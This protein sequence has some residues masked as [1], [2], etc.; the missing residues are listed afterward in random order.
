VLGRNHRRREKK[1]SRQETIAHQS[2][3]FFVIHAH[4]I[5]PD[6]ARSSTQ[7]AMRDVQK[8][9]VRRRLENDDRGT[10]TNLLNL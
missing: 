10:R 7:R 2:F 5:H 1:K 9:D 4:R 3:P 6:H 8:R